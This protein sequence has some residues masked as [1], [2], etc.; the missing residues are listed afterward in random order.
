MR[1]RGTS[2]ANTPTGAYLTAHVVQQPQSNVTTVLPST[3]II[4]NNSGVLPGGTVL[5]AQI[6]PS[7][8]QTAPI[9]AQQVQSQQANQSM[10]QQTMTQI[11]QQVQVSDEKYLSVSFGSGE[12]CPS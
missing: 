7:Q 5:A 10:Q 11:P 2:S 3:A 4:P 1:Q 12:L 6:Q 8:I 9:Q